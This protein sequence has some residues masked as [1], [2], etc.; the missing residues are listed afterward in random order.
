MGRL[1]DAVNQQREALAAREEEAAG[2]VVRAYGYTWKRLEPQ[3]EQFADDVA[4]RLAAGETIGPGK[5]G[6]LERLR[7]LKTQV[8]E[9]LVELEQHAGDTIEREQRD[10]VQAAGGHL[11]ELTRLAAGRAPAAAANTIAA[12]WNR[13]PDAAVQA[14]VGA[15]A[16]GSPLAD[17]LGEVAGEGAVEFG[18]AL[19][20]G[21]ALGLNP[22]EV[23]AQARRALGTPLART[24]RI[25]RTETL[26]AYREATRLD[27][28]ANPDVI[29]GWVWH[30]ALGRRT[31]AACWAMHGTVHAADEVLDG[32]PNCRCAMVPQTLS[33]EDMGFKGLKDTRPKIPNGPDLFADAGAETQQAVL[34]NESYRRYRS[35]ELA[36]VDLLARRDNADW[37][38]MR[39]ARSL[40]QVDRAG[41]GEW[42]G[43][44]ALP[45]ASGGAVR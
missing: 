26:R 1:Q 16:D 24:L 9:R 27:L 35:G 12:N 22:R 28:V 2:Q 38:T 13:V 30:S 8:A 25:A 21:L 19:T 39:Y 17:L 23:A 6:R 42:V 31:C 44:A 3:V 10:A 45:V 37:G 40:R 14:L 32:H 5:L 36:L 33:W 4:R 15:L 18:E 43:A 41:G 11:L 34:G 7:T 20:T 29:G